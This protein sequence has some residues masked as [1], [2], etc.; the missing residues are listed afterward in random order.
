MVHF[1]STFIRFLLFSV[2]CLDTWWTVLPRNRRIFHWDLTF[3]FPHF[4]ALLLL[5]WVP[6]C[7]QSQLLSP[8]TAH[9]EG[10]TGKR[11]K[12]RCTST[13]KTRD[14]NNTIPALKIMTFAVAVY[15][16]LSGCLYLVLPTWSSNL[17]RPDWGKTGKK[18]KKRGLKMRT[19]ELTRI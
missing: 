19:T 15:I 6:P 3:L 2:P 11:K 12:S 18:R 13:Q 17:S 5:L 14:P 9:F 8:V 7:F 10:K 4:L 1:R 16:L